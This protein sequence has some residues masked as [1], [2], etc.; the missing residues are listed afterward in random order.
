MPDKNRTDYTAFDHPEVVSLLFH[1]RQGAVRNISSSSLMPVVI[2]VEGSE[3]IGA[4]LHTAGKSSPTVLFFHGNGEIVSDYDDIG[5]IFTK[6]RINFFPVDYRGY[7]FSSGTPT[8]SSMMTDCQ[9]VFDYVRS[10]LAESGYTG[11]LIVMGRSLGSACALELADARVDEISGLIIES[12]FAFVLPL[13]RL[14]GVDTV[15]LG[16]TEAK[17]FRNIDKA[18]RC[19]LPL[20]VIHAEYD[21]IIPFSDGQAL[22]D[23]SPSLDKH[24]IK[25]PG[26]DHNTIFYYGMDDYMSGVNMFIHNLAG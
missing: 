19:H 18:S 2:P 22:F 21:H 12:G 4:S 14:M 25:I 5:V 8:V 15:R 23:R 26:A 11:K 9:A 16:L 7:G 1:P 17:G 24:F 10:W 6:H 13:L 3:T 20:L